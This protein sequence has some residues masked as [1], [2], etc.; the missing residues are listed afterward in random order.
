MT[1]HLA[2]GH[3]ASVKC[4]PLFAHSSTD[5]SPLNTLASC[6]VSC[7]GSLCG[8]GV[9]TPFAYRPPETERVAIAVAPGPP[10]LRVNLSA[11][12]AVYSV[13]AV[14]RPTESANVHGSSTV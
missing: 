9:H 5:T 14:E 4:R 13:A 2:T 1:L 12:Y 10:M 6:S 11:P 3:S 7:T 8:S